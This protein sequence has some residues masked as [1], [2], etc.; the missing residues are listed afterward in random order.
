MRLRL[1]VVVLVCGVLAV[2]WAAGGGVASATPAPGEEPTRADEKKTPSFKTDV[3]PILSNACANCHG[4]KKKKGRV[5]TSSYAGVL[6]TVKVNEPDKSQLVKAVTGQG[7]KLM[8]PK[9][10]LSDAQVKIIKDWIAAG[11]KDD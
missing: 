2:C 6:K 3:M 7:A 4:G 1:G 8:P 10:G 9:V 11:A 5:D